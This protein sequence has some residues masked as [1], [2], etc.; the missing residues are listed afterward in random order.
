VGYALLLECSFLAIGALVGTL[1]GTKAQ[2]FGY[3]LFIWFFFVLFYDLLAMGATF[4]LSERAGN[5]FIFISIFGNPVALD[6]VGSLMALGDPAVFG[7]AGAALVKFLGGHALS[8]LVLISGLIIWTV[9]PITAVS[10]TLRKR[11]I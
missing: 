6:R 11:D 2:A 5:R 8:N 3:S 10:K 4:L 7:Y 1:S 9:V